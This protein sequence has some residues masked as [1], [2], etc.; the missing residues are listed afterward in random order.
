MLHHERFRLDIR[1]KFILRKSDEELEPLSLS[2]DQET[3]RYGSEEHG[4]VSM[5]GMGSRWD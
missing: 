4:L 2:N 1:K 5:V 3:C